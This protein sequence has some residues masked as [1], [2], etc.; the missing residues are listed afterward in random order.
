MV[1]SSVSVVRKKDLTAEQDGNAAI[2]DMSLSWHL[3][4][5]G[6]KLLNILSLWEIQLMTR[7]LV[8]PMENAP[9][10]Q[11]E[12]QSNINAFPHLMRTE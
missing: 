8:H 2:S 3:K 5:N 12:I 11:E 4:M 7:F 10:K 1:L 9:S 6:P